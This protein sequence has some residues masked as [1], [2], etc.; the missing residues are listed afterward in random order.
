M[1]KILVVDDDPA[2][3][4]VI[5]GALAREGHL[6]LHATSGKQGMELLARERL[7]LRSLTT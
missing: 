4:Q 1:G 7:T 2:L 5:E 6:L 3:H